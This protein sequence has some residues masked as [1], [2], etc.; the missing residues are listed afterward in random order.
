[1]PF[2]KTVLRRSGGHERGDRDG[3]DGTTPSSDTVDG[4]PPRTADQRYHE[5]LVGIGEQLAALL[6]VAGQLFDELIADNR[7]ICDRTDRLKRRIDDLTKIVDRLDAKSASIPEGTVE[8]VSQVTRHFEVDHAFSGPSTFD[9]INRPRSV[10][11]LYLKAAPTPIE[12]IRECDCYRTD[13]MRGAH[14]FSRCPVAVNKWTDDFCTP[15]KVQVKRR[16]ALSLRTRRIRPLQT[17]A[18][19]NSLS[20]NQEDGVL[21]GSGTASDG[22]SIKTSDEV[23][24]EM[25]ETFPPNGDLQ[26]VLVVD[27]DITGSS[28]N[29]LHKLHAQ[30]LSFEAKGDSYPSAS[31]VRYRKT[32]RRPKTITGISDLIFQEVDVDMPSLTQSGSTKLKGGHRRSLKKQSSQ[33]LETYAPKERSKSLKKKGGKCLEEDESKSC[34]S[35]RHSLKSVFRLSRS[36]SKNLWTPAGADESLNKSEKD[37]LTLKRSTSLP[38]T[39]KS[40]TKQSVM[41][42]S[43]RSSSVEGRLNLRVLPAGANRLS[44]TSYLQKPVAGER[45]GYCLTKSLSQMRLGHHPSKMQNFGVTGR[46]QSME[47]RMPMLDEEGRTMLSIYNSSENKVSSSTT[48]TGGSM[49][50][51]PWAKSL[52]TVKLRNLESRYNKD[53]CQSSSGRWSGSSGLTEKQLQDCERQLS[54]S[55][56]V[57]QSSSDMSFGTK[58]SAMS[59]QFNPCEQESSFQNKKAAKQDILL[60]RN[61]GLQSKTVNGDQTLSPVDK[62]FCVS[63]PTSSECKRISSSGRETHQHHT[64]YSHHSELDDDDYDDDEN[65]SSRPVSFIRAT[66]SNSSSKSKSSYRSSFMLRLKKLGKSNKLEAPDVSPKVSPVSP[67]MTTMGDCISM[68]NEAIAQS[69]TPCLPRAQSSELRKLAELADRMAMT[70]SKA[71]AAS[72]LLSSPVFCGSAIEHE[73]DVQNN[74]PLDCQLISV[75]KEHQNLGPNAINLFPLE[76]CSPKSLCQ[77]NPGCFFVHNGKVQKVPSTTSMETDPASNAETST[78][79]SKVDQRTTAK[80][81]KAI[82]LESILET[83][84]DCEMG[85]PFIVRSKLAPLDKAWLEKPNS[86]KHLSSSDVWTSAKLVLPAVSSSLEN[87]GDNAKGETKDRGKH[88]SDID[89]DECSANEI[90]TSESSII[91]VLPLSI[92]NEKD[93]TDCL[94]D[95]IPTTARLI[96]SSPVASRA[97]FVDNPHKRSLCQVLSHDEFAKFCTGDIKSGESP[98]KNKSLSIFSEP[99]SVP[100]QPLDSLKHSS[101]FSVTIRERVDPSS[102]GRTWHDDG[103]SNEYCPDQAKTS[104]RS[105]LLPLGKQNGSVRFSDSSNVE[106]DVFQR[107]KLYTEKMKG[108]DLS[109]LSSSS[110]V[111]N[112]NSDD[113]PRAKPS[114]SAV[115]TCGVKSIQEKKCARVVFPSIDALQTSQASQSHPVSNNLALKCHDISNHRPSSNVNVLKLK[116]FAGSGPVNDASDDKYSLPNNGG[117]LNL[118]KSHNVHF[119]RSNTLPRSYPSTLVAREEPCV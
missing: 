20:N 94:L 98:S 92:N 27:I 22:R 79:T 13:G 24:S 38:R 111:R 101:G 17:T 50:A 11:K 68:G 86:T 40:S 42:R 35:I 6:L 7:L 34:N 88:L 62:P 44:S 90:S 82:E 116:T 49:E 16:V 3:G 110:P 48:I 53:D 77:E 100:K 109:H 80:G 106:K 29:K 63:S 113:V 5:S 51:H 19:S 26:A 91:S 95:P 83:S 43:F 12:H 15:G 105:S 47:I 36:R 31:L 73:F 54:G 117:T 14:L 41:F 84:H 9:P 85:S 104:L 21:D 66:E 89:A 8:A 81:Q 61:N 87:L 39:L 76:V 75:G 67:S 56:L 30:S 97:A 57:V 59:L 69:F 108:Y 70:R 28:F 74:K 18:E 118:K 37:S 112:L 78:S 45:L 96:I 2:A 102:Y 93:V 99:S 72:P 10:H 23:F 107:Q 58:D 32:M 119:V 1:M 55:T 33:T 46:P 114:S 60:V 25:E 52:S 65:F 103:M 64:I 71:K 115:V 4:K